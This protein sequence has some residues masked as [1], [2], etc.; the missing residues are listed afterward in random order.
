MGAEEMTRE[1]KWTMRERRF[2]RRWAREGKTREDMALR[3]GRSLKSV[4][5]Q[6]H[7][8]RIL[9]RAS[10]RWSREET[11]KLKRLFDAGK[12]YPEIAMEL[13]RPYWAVVKKVERVILAGPEMVKLPKIKRRQCQ[14]GAWFGSTGFHHRFCRKCRERM[15]GKSDVLD[16]NYSDLQSQ[17]FAGK[18]G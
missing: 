14:C 11:A 9:K 2:L 15:R 7:R 1:K 6:L 16:F 12:S 17:A 5:H 18:L 8:M 10:N 13:G 4:Q 3:L